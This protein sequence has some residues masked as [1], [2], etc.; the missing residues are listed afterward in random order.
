VSLADIVSAQDL[1]LWAELGLVVSLAT[2]G[3]IVVYVLRARR[4]RDW[5]RARWLPLAGDEGSE[6]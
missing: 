4:Q 6:E 2:F 5:E 1:V 3:G